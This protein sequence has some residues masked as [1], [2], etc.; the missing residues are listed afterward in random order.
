MKVAVNI[1]CLHP[2]LTGIGHYACH[3][4]RE[5]LADPRVESLVG[6]SHSGWHSR[7]E[8]GNMVAHAQGFPVAASSAL[9]LATVA[10]RLR[11]LLRRVPGLKR[12]RARINH[13]RRHKAGRAHRDYVYWEPNYLLLPIDNPAV[14]TVHDISHLRHPEYHPAERLRELARLVDSIDR[15]RRVITASRFS[16]GEIA[17]VLGVPENLIDVVSPAVSDRFRPHRAEARELV[18]QRYRLPD[19]YI[20]FCGTLE[21]R[22]NVP[23]LMQAFSRLPA[24]LQ[25]RYPL[26][27]A[28]GRGWHRGEF[29][30]MLAQL[31]NPNILP[32]G[33][34]NFDDLPALYSAATIFA[35]PSL[36]EGFGMPVLEAMA[37]GTAVVTSRTSSMPEV[38]AGAALLVEPG[39]VVAIADALEALLEDADKRDALAQAGLQAAAKRSWQQ[40]Y[41]Q[42]F[43]SLTAAAP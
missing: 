12:M 18:R 29:E 3:L 1:H 17:A 32:L 27:L 8:V 5:M 15:S 39:D 30:A 20:L 23:R 11:Q 35:Y 24:A 13:A 22:K 42:L 21:P 6:L 2:P 28:G 31:A 38:A 37:S 10:T 16:R 14:A 41:A 4:L 36:Y 40:S 43:A 9:P 7:E 25:Y 19:G 34:V 26:V 33:Y